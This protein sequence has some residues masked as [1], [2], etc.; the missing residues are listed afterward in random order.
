MPR[1]GLSWPFG[2]YILSEV[3]GLKTGLRVAAQCQR[4]V[5]LESLKALIPAEAAEAPI[6]VLS[7]PHILSGSEAPRMPTG[8]PQLRS[9]RFAAGLS[10]PFDRLR[11]SLQP[12]APR[13]ARQPAPAAVPSS[14][15]TTFSSYTSIS[16]A[17]GHRRQNAPAMWHAGHPP[18]R[19]HVSQKHAI[20]VVRGHS[21]VHLDPHRNARTSL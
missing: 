19:S 4:A 7:V 13:P 11:T 6:S 8:R 17:K 5:P 14:Q 21:L 1:A 20:D 3:E 15:Q 9:P 16:Q 2:G 18:G 10:W 12:A